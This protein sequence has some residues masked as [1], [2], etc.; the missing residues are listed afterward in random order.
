MTH[1]L[2][3]LSIN[4]TKAGTTWHVG[5][6]TSS[7]PQGNVASADSIIQTQP[8]ISKTIKAEL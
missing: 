3:F 2:L 5:G 4:L 1:Y 8:T 6:M 7:D